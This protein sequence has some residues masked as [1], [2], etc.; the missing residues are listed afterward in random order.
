MCVWKEISMGAR[1]LSD[2]LKLSPSRICG[3]NGYYSQEYI[4]YT[5]F[6]GRFFVYM[7]RGKYT[8]GVHSP[9]IRAAA[10]PISSHLPPHIFI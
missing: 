2:L 3:E 8:S 1:E 5:R 6:R 7:F 10:E 4:I 9:P